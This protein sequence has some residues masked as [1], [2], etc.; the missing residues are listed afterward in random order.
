MKSSMKTILKEWRKYQI[1][2]MS[3]IYGEDPTDFDESIFNK[4]GTSKKED[5]SDADLENF[6]TEVC[7]IVE[8]SD[9]I[10]VSFVDKYDNEVPSLG[11]NPKIS[12]S[13]PHGIY[14]YPLNRDNLYHFLT[15]GQPTSANFATDK[16][17]LHIYRVNDLNTIK[18]K[19][20]FDTN[21]NE[22]NYVKDI[23]TIISFYLNYLTS[24]LF[25]K[26]NVVSFFSIFYEQNK[27]ASVESAYNMLLRREN[28]GPLVNSGWSSN[29][30][31]LTK[32]SDNLIYFIVFLM[33]I[34]IIKKDSNIPSKIINMVSSFFDFIS[35]TELNRFDDR[36]NNS[37]FYKIYF[38]SKT[39]SCCIEN[40]GAYQIRD[41]ML[42]KT[43]NSGGMFTL[44]LNSININGINDSEG[45]SLLHDNEP[46]QSVV[47][48]TSN[49]DNFELLGTYYNV[50]R[51]IEERDDLQF[52]QHR[53]NVILEKL[54]EAGKVSST[55]FRSNKSDIE[56]QNFS[57]I[58]HEND[59]DF[60]YDD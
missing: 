22:I 32:I 52:H 17:Y 39:L 30:K 14:G 40:I 46:S 59:L 21:Y 43:I 33:K 18:I 56:R 58:Q 5:R 54:T 35:E 48:D 53:V 3:R 7:E 12:W 51:N 15:T 60:L 28:P 1:D 25:K 19:Q 57:L 2:E 49:S 47:I 50:F 45:T 26:P 37:S 42:S 16:E 36:V 29:D 6:I 31:R 55:I 10:F 20:N 27:T 41:E 8:K 11:V 23:R 4:A 38:I 24:M 9:N 13:T 44:L 34:D